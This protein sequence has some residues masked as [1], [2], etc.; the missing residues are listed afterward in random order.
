MNP[1][2]ATYGENFTAEG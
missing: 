1:I 2:N